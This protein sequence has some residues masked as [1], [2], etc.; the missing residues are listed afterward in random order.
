MRWPVSGVLVMAALLGGPAGVSRGADREPT[1]T[2]AQLD[3]AFTATVAALV[4]RAEAVG[5]AALAAHIAAWNRPMPVDRQVAFLIPPRL[6]RPPELAGAAAEVWSDFLA[7]RRRR[8]TGLFDHALAAARAHGRV[9]GRAELAAPAADR[10]PVLQRSS[11]AIALIYRTLRDDPDHE[12]A[13]AAAGYLKRGDAWV[14]PQ[15][16]RRLDRGE[17]Y[18][19]AFG[20]LPRGRL[21]R[22]RAGERHD[23]GTW[24]TVAED[25]ART[26][27]VDRGRR[28]DSD[29]WEILSAAPLEAAAALASRLEETFIVWQQVFGTIGVSPQDLQKRL[30]ARGAPQGPEPFAAVLCADRRQYIDEL[31][32]LEPSVHRAD[33]IYWTPTRTAWFFHESLEGGGALPRADTVHHEATHQLCLEAGVKSRISPLAG[34]R[35]G[36]WAIEAIACHMES[37]RAMPDGWTVGGRD[38]GRGPRARELLTDGSLPLTVAE[39]ASLGRKEFQTHGRLEDVYTEAA[40]LADFLLNGSSGRYREA[41]LE[42]CGRVYS[43]TADPETL[44]RLCRTSAPEL[45]TEFRTYLRGD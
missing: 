44:A 35:C 5:D 14:W 43:G 16:A 28:F 17:E 45:D 13:R 32:R 37:I 4:R 20:W 41:F 38:A 29:H 10:P 22:Y 31:S 42:Y 8:A 7:A 2:I 21:A 3:E 11:A 36:F 6:E 27:T 1:T 24:M 19:A 33:G 9:P 12:R 26:L 18:D 34:E 23:R 25:A 15:A 40:A 39:L 30:V